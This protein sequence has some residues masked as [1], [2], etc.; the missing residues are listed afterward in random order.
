[1]RILGIDPGLA[2]VGYGLV[3]EN[4]G[5]TFKKIDYGHISTPKG[6]ELPR[7][8]GIIFNSVQQLIARFSPD[9]LALEKLF[10]CKNVKTALQVGEARGAIITAAVLNET[11]V[12]EYTPLQVK[13]AVA[14][15]GRAE[16]K[17]VQQMVSL[18][19]K[20]S[21]IP[22]PDDAADALAVALCHLQSRRWQKLTARLLQ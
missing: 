21:K 7:R 6:L 12:F 19:L 16:K 4:E 1:M 15:Y 20:L 8:L 10:F 9:E 17:Q 22:R 18:L 3:E 2:M 11:P 14:G 5:S 13:Q